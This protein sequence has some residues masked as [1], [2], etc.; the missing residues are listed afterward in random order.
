MKESEYEVMANVEDRHFWFVITRAIVRDELTRR[1]MGKDAI[2]LD[3]GAGTGG[4]IRALRGLGRF[5]G[6]DLS[7]QACSF[8]AQR[9]NAPYVM[10]SALQIPLKDKSVDAVLAL[11]VF[12]HIKDD[13]CAIREVRRV[14]KDGGV[15]LA[16]VPCHPWLYSAH[17]VALHHVRR[18]RKEDFLCLLRDC[19]FSVVRASYTNCFLFPIIA[20]A[21][22]VGKLLK[23][24]PKSDATVRLGALNQVFKMI[25][26]IERHI[27]KHTDLPWGVSLIVVGK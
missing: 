15:L 4:T 19:G 25:F 2:I 17:D 13:A 27:L 9:T 24:E 12:E 26:G 7:V 8:G 10:G 14:L 20:G 23:R 11:D 21:R 6:L 3:L 16:T 18:Y 1:L 22:V 5:I